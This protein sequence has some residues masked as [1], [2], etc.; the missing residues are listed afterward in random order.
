MVLSLAEA[1]KLEPG[2]ILV[3]PSTMPAWT[4]L[5]AS[6]A[7]VVTDA[8]GILSHSGIVAREHN[9]P[10]GLGTGTVTSVIQDGQILEVDG[11]AGIV[12]MV[13]TP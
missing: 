7:A 13:K 3:A 4:P 11:D 9:I 1:G 8:G 10:A 6:I 2:D 12:R 5:F